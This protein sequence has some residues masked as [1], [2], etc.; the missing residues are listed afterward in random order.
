MLLFL[1]VF[2]E[3]GGGAPY[4]VTVIVWENVNSSTQTLA[5]HW[6][7]AR[8]FPWPVWF[9][10]SR[11]V[12]PVA[13][14]F[15]ISWITFVLIPD[16]IKVALKL[17][18]HCGGCLLCQPN[19]LNIYPD[20]PS[21]FLNKLILLFKGF[22]AEINTFTQL[23]LPTLHGGSGQNGGGWRG[24]GQWADFGQRGDTA[25]LIF[26]VPSCVVVTSPVGR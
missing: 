3:A 1:C 22:Y 5:N 14:F 24:F 9:T 20:S 6:K 25:L 15:R 4:K 10:L 19:D 7:T 16:G 21:I 26:K 8:L 13:T 18:E 23:T 12:A 11:T 17:K 2:G